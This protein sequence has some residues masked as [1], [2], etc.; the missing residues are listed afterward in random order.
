ME[1]TRSIPKSLRGAA[2]ALPDR[3]ELDSG[4]VPLTIRRNPRA[5]RMIMRLAPGA[6]GVSV[7]VPARAPVKTILAFIDRHRDWAASRVAAAPD[8]LTV[9]P[10]AELPFRG[11]PVRIV[12]E[13]ARRL[14]HFETG[15]ESEPARLHVGG[16]PQHLRR[17]VADFLKREARRDL[18][19]AVQRHA[20]AVGLAPAAI[21]LKD[22]TSRWGSCTRERRL[23]FSWRIVMAPP[24]VLDYLAAHEVA[25]FKEMNHGPDFWALCRT[26]CPEMDAGRDWLKRHGAGLHAIAFD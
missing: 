19:A 11:Q 7:T 20:A 6:G 17:R 10:G 12:H 21:T 4:P 1:L 15:G 23:A 26:L 9:A 14:S 22:T 8:R 2:P 13:P 18:E 5:K 3:L 24:F 25:H 16:E